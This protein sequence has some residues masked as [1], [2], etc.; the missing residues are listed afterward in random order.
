MS[1]PPI[2]SLHHSDQPIPRD[3]ARRHLTTCITFSPSIPP[4]P[5]SRR[6][7]K[8]Q[9]CDSCSRRKVSCDKASPSCSR[10]RR[11]DLPCSYLRLVGAAT[12]ADGA[13]PDFA[14]FRSMTD[15]NVVGTEDAVG[16]DMLT[17]ELDVYVQGGMQ[18]P[19]LWGPAAWMMEDANLSLSLDHTPISPSPVLSARTS[20]IITALSSTQA[21]LLPNV[22][23][24]LPLAETVFTPH[25][26][27]HF[28]WVYRTR[29]H[30][31][32]PLLHPPSFRL[33]LA[34]TPLLLV[35]FLFGALFSAPLDDALAARAFFRVAEEY[36]FERPEVKRLVTEGGV[37][38]TKCGEE[39]VEVLQAALG[40]LIIQNS[41]ND[42]VVRRRIRIERLPSL[43]A[44]VRYAGAFQARHRIKMNEYTAEMWEDFIQ[45]ELLIR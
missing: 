7:K 35:V 31:Y 24:D 27:E 45:D 13:G 28:A 39:T 6:G 15:P 4:L 25:N 36:V 5:T 2:N 14:W 22:P 32:H 29:V 17:D 9:S 16:R 37:K 8:P 43:N 34:S 44:A 18:E 10:C 38:G 21:S 33:E 40:I 3:V 12:T 42:K 30:A 19:F 1:V 23:F 11:A 20:E 41:R 26:L